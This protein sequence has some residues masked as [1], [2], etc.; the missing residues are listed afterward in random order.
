M[1]HGSDSPIP[2][3]YSPFDCQLNEDYHQK[4]ARLFFYVLKF[5]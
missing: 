5:K 2:V 3:L 1:V 4:S